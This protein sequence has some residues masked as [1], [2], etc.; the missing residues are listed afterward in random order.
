MAIHRAAKPSPNAQ[1][2]LPLCHAAKQ[3]QSQLLRH[4]L[5]RAGPA[6]PAPAY[7]DIDAQP[8]N[9]VVMALFRAKMA[10]AIG[11]DSKLDG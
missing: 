10:A 8:L 3:R 2:R 5:P 4:A 9:K 7:T 6:T 1:L 11:S